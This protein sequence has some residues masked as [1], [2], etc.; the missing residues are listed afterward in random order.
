MSWQQ[1]IASKALVKKA[2]HSHIIK[3]RA[4]NIIY[5]RYILPDV[6][7]CAVADVPSR[8]S[9]TRAAGAVHIQKRMQNMGLP[10]PPRLSNSSG[11]FEP[12]EAI[13]ALAGGLQRHAK[14]ARQEG[15]KRMQRSDRE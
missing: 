11:R 13:C 7:V 4:S 8:R 12:A 10:A 2:R 15:A 14:S 1:L 9:I 6:S 5:L 3:L